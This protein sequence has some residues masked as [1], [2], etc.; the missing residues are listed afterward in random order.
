MF[1][2]RG[3][4]EPTI[5]SCP[6]GTLKILSRKTITIKPDDD[7]ASRYFA[8]VQSNITANT[9]ANRRFAAIQSD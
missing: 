8:V 1:E 6:I 7:V 4:N 9:A 2:W 5:E 3:F